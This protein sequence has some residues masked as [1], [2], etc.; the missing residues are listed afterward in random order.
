M[1]LESKLKI[2]SPTIRHLKGVQKLPGL[3]VEHC[4]D[5]VNCSASKVLAIRRI[6][7]REGEFA[8]NIIFQWTMEKV[9]NSTI[10]LDSRCRV[11]IKMQIHYHTFGVQL[12]LLLA[13]LHAVEVHL[14]MFVDVDHWK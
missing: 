12:V 4:N 10:N 14:E 13:S 5:P 11:K 3:H 8:C 9:S 6:G 7:K 2:S 1:A